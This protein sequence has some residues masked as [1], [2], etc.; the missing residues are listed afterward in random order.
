MLKILASP[1][2]CSKEWIIR[3]YDHEVQGGSV[4]K[5]LVG[6]HDDGP[7]DADFPISALG[8]VPDV[9]RCVPI[10]TSRRAC[11]T[12][13]TQQSKQVSSVPATISAKALWPQQR[14]RLPAAWAQT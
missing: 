1:N 3:Q 9:R 2:V 10:R 5:P 6:L 7:S 13:C 4:V 11:S 14:W 12:N 8:R